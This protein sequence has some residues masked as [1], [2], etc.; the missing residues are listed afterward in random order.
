MIQ[1]EVGTD[2]LLSFLLE[3]GSETVFPRAIIYDD[4][5]AT[6]ATLSMSS[7]ADG[8]YRVLH[9]GLVVGSYQVVF[10]S[11]DDAGFTIPTAN[12]SRGEESVEVVD[13]VADRVLN[14]SIAGRTANGTFGRALA[15]AG[16]HAGHNSVLDGGAGFSSVQNNTSNNL[17][18]CRLRV[19]ATEAAALAA[20][21][22]AADGADGE[23]F[24]MEFAGQYNSAAASAAL[25]VLAN[26]SRTT[27]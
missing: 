13:V 4:A 11:F 12:I 26:I 1:I 23:E 16:A 14:A 21:P 5:G 15:L 10:E 3:S 8:L 9:P 18:T 20:T 24:R 6:V 22:G 27:P 25:Q 2:L 17:E 7:I 19:F